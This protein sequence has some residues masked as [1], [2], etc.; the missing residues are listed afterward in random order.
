MWNSS[1]L[2]CCFATPSL[3][4]NG[5]PG[6]KSLLTFHPSPPRGKEPFFDAC[7][8]GVA[9]VTP[10]LTAITHVPPPPNGKGEALTLRELMHIT[11]P[12]FFV[13][14]FLF[15]FLSQRVS[16]LPPLPTLSCFR[17]LRANSA[18][19]TTT[20]EARNRPICSSMRSVNPIR[21]ATS[22][23]RCRR[24]PGTTPSQAAR[25]PHRTCSQRSASR[26]SQG[27]HLSWW[28]G[29]RP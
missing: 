24:C 23:R 16:A 19:S 28:N 6:I 20:A 4:K 8:V 25:S 1:V 14:V 21:T 27:H 10:A 17:P 13:S 2:F 18:W 26:S 3:R 29:H 5:E 11:P 9:C 15:F 7:L 12:P 22:K